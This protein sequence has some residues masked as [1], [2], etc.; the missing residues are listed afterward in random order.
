[1]QSPR[2]RRHILLFLNFKSKPM[3]KK[4]SPVE[5]QPFPSPLINLSEQYTWQLWVLR[6]TG[7]KTHQKLLYAWIVPDYLHVNGWQTVISEFSE[8]VPVADG[9]TGKI[10]VL[11][12]EFIGNGHE[13][14]HYITELLDGKLL[15]EVELTDE[16]ILVPAQLNNLSLGLDKK[17][18]NQNY[19]VRPE[20]FLPVEHSLIP[21]PNKS[22]PA[23]TGYGVFVSELFYLPK[24]DLFKELPVDIHH[25]KFISLLKNI[26]DLLA[27]TT[28]FR[29]T[30]ES[31]PR[32]GNIEWFRFPISDSDFQPMIHYQFLKNENS[33]GRQVQIIC[34]PQILDK[35]KKTTWSNSVLTID[36]FSQEPVSEIQV[37]VWEV[38]SETGNAH[39]IFENSNVLLRT[40]HTVM[41][42]VQSQINSGRI[43]LLD[44]LDN[45][46]KDK[47]VELAKFHRTAK[48]T[49]MNTGDYEHDP[50][51]SSAHEVLAFMKKQYPEPSGAKFF[52]NGW[53]SEL[54]A[55]G[56]LSFFEWIMR[57]IDS[58]QSG[59]LLLIDPFFDKDG[60]EIFANSR[61]SNKKIRI[62]TCT[63]HRV[64]KKTKTAPG[65]LTGPAKK[66]RANCVYMSPLLAGLNIVIS[67]LTSPDGGKKQLFHD[68]YLLL[69][70]ENGF[71]TEGY[72][73]S[74]SI[75]GATR[76]EPILITPIP[77]DI[78]PSVLKYMGDLLDTTKINNTRK[79]TLVDIFPVAP[80]KSDTAM[81]A[82][83]KN[84]NRILQE[85]PNAAY[86]F[87]NVYNNGKLRKADLEELEVFL[88]SNGL[89]EGDDSSIQFYKI[90]AAQL[91]HFS[92]VL[93]KASQRKFNKLML[94]LGQALAR[95]NYYSAVYN[96]VNMLLDK[97]KQKPAIADKLIAFLWDIEPDKK[98]R[99]I[100]KY[101][102]VYTNE[103]FETVVHDTARQV[104]YMGGDFF[105]LP[106]HC[107]YACKFLVNG[108]PA[109]AVK[110]LEQLVNEAVAGGWNE[111]DGTLK[112]K[113]ML[114]SAINHRF[115]RYY[116]VAEQNVQIAFLS[117]RDFKIRAA[118]SAAIIG[119]IT[120]YFQRQEFEHANELLKNTLPD[121]EYRLAIS[122]LV[123]DI[124]L[125]RTLPQEELISKCY[126]A[127]TANWNAQPALLNRIIPVL[128]GPLEYS[129][130]YSISKLLLDPLIAGRH[131]DNQWA[132]Q[133]WD[134]LFTGKVQ[135]RE[136][137]KKTPDHFSEHTDPDLTKSVIYYFLKLPNSEQ[138]NILE[139]WKKL[140]A[141]MWP[142]ILQPFQAQIN[143]NLL[144][145]STERIFWINEI[146]QRLTQEHSL[147]PEARGIIDDFLTLHG[148]ALKK[149]KNYI[150]QKGYS[151]IK[152]LTQSL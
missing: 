16:N 37:T 55:S 95:S 152:N 149:V 8:H 25:D 111:A 2:R 70:D 119:G 94:S 131:I 98:N 6:S 34:D 136:E 23:P 118:A 144:D 143:Y 130:S 53:E 141:P 15:S 1:M 90:T 129:Y 86:L 125:N 58:T 101:Y 69:T 46:E 31:A 140:I 121:E 112:R 57:I 122:S 85:I 127:I 54:N 21:W 78:L 41:S 103:N 89:I 60:I 44:K 106:F 138:V 123:H 147:Q 11:K 84:A 104:A 33:I 20:V 42:M 39:I 88:Q 82:S 18:A 45:R 63:Q 3:M 13:I 67:D 56:Q 27:S 72:H 75:Q 4:I 79:T 91:K 100:A 105:G 146:F 77:P 128:A 65:S 26:A 102:A 29:F 124:R 64:K 108:F 28:G 139:H 151:A 17:E 99:G 14:K 61:T 115:L 52:I 10:E 120:A 87:A 132:F 12:A 117:S 142:F 109:A 74:N 36:F 71:A 22:T 135:Y 107:Y 43:N 93:A 62:L 133:F 48:A 66:I 145:A 150:N 137:L 81:P 83:S 5:K 51:V 92:D 35:V 49:T 24:L 148:L 126:K 116:T 47:P 134:N 38:N 40:M 7:L 114:I 76:K 113:M 68:R 19:I 96:A 50:W 73:L 59:S 80:K 97:M 110:L 30:K 32:F 9:K